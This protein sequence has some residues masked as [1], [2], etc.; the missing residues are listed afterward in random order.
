M[1]SWLPFK[2]MMWMCWQHFLFKCSRGG[3]TCI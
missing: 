1:I 2:Y 3:N